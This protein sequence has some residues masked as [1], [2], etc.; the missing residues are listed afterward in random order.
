MRITLVTA[1]SVV[2]RK[3]IERLRQS[4]VRE[5]LGF[6]KS[7]WM[8]PAV[9]RER[10]VRVRHLVR[11]LALLHRVAL[12]RRGVEQL[13]GQLLLHG[14]AIGAVAG[15][16]DD[17]AHAERGG[18]IG[19]NVDGDLV[20]GATDA[21]GLHLDLGLNVLHGAIPHLYRIIFRL[22]GDDV[23]GAVDDALG[24]RLLAV[25]HDRV[26][27]LRH[28]AALID[29]LIGVLG[30][31]KRLALRNFTFSWHVALFLWS[32]LLGTLGAVFRSALT[33]V[34][35]ARGVERAANDVVANA[36]QILHAATADQNDRVLLQ[37][38][39]LAGDVGGHFHAVRQAHA[40]DLAQGRVRLLRR[41]RVNA[42]A[43]ATALRAGLERGRVRFELRLGATELDELIDGGHSTL[44]SKILLKSRGSDRFW[45][46]PEKT[47][48]TGSRG[49]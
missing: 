44:T 4:A 17:P 43:D 47:P 39:P 46:R 19:A 10:L 22:L 45:G 38:V 13:A 18:A 8:L 34:V 12:V 33:A 7:S 11:V 24:D 32:G 9:V 37:V 30:I 31:G 28:A 16:A 27:E 21:A 20:G 6:S 1:R 29:R 40:R 42:H 35:D 2:W 25:P 26:D 5:V 14:A 49:L 3:K 36:R 48:D 15:G 23:E 41:G